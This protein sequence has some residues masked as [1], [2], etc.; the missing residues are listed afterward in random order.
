[1]QGDFRFLPLENGLDFLLS[2]LEHLTAASSV[3]ILG[4][5]LTP[6]EARHQKR[7]LKYA[8][9][10]L[11]SSIEVLFKV[12]LRQEHWSFV[13]ANVNRAD[14]EAQDEGAF[15]SVAF[16]DLMDRLVRICHIDLSEEQ[17]RLLTNLRKRRNRMEHLGTVD[18]L[19]AISASVSSMV[20]FTIDFVES[21]FKPDDLKEQQLLIDEIRH[22]LGSCNAFIAQ[23]WQEIRK[24][25]DAF[26]SVIECPACQQQ[27]LEVN[28][29]RVRCRFCYH[30]SSSVEA[31]NEYIYR[32]LG[33]F[34]GE[35]A[36]NTCPECGGHTL[37]GRIPDR[38]SF[39][40]N[41]GLEWAPGELERCWACNEFYA[42]ED[43]DCGICP[44]CFQAGHEKD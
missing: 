4:L 33:H 35:S 43:D 41:C 16:H 11:C 30:A 7:H 19:P 13:F 31:A 10:H 18:S 17:R 15:E 23:R 24:D 26:Y 2:S 1:M 28:K 20:S 8:L 9:L 38:G 40:F 29:G 6:D 44:A 39:C 14:D 3:A 36:V 5:F 22:Q 37:V 25:V 12:R 27:A 32:F 42:T 34:S 21:T